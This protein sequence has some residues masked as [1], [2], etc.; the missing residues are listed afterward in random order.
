MTQNFLSD[1]TIYNLSPQQRLI[2][3]YLMTGRALTRQVAI[4][5]LNVQEVTTR[6]SELKR[7]GLEIKSQFKKDFGGTRYKAYWVETEK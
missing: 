7:L 3:D 2:Y 4:N 5:T 6:I 1:A